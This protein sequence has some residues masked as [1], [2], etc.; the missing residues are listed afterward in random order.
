MG[1]DWAAMS[2]FLGGV[3]AVFLVLLGPAAEAQPDAPPGVQQVLLLQG[4]IAATSSS[5]P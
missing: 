1:D 4:P 2:R 3:L 5:I